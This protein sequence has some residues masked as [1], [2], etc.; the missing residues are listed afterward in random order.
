MNIDQKAFKWLDSNQLSYDIWNKKYRFKGESFDD[1][2][3]RVSSNNENIKR[4]ILEKK[5]SFGG[6]ILANRGLNHASLANCATLGRVKDSINGIMETNTQLAQTFKYQ[7]GQGLSLTDIRP[8]GTPIRGLYPSEG[9]VPFME[10]FNT[11]TESIQQGGSRRGALLMALDIMHK[12]AYD[13]MTIK[14]DLKR[15]NNANLSMEISDEFMGYVEECMANNTNK[16]IHMK[17]QYGND[18]IEYDVDVMKLYNTLCE[19]A[20]KYAEPGILYTD[21]LFNYNLMQHDDDYEILSTNACS[22]QPLVKHGM[23]MLASIN[24][25]KYVQNPFSSDVKFD[26]NSL[27]YDIYDIVKAMDDIVD[28][29]IKL[30]PLQEQKDT[31]QK[32][33]NIGVGIMG[34]A[35]FFVMNNVKY[36][37]N[38]SKQMARDIMKT[39]FQYAIDA[40]VRLGEERGNFPGYKSCVWDSDIIKA[41]ISPRDIEKYKSKGCLRNC[42]LLS[43]APTGSIGTMFQ[44]STGCEPFFALSYKR[45]TISMGEQYYDVNIPTLELYK[46]IKGE[47]ADISNFVTS[48]DIHWVDRIGVQSELQKACDTAISSTCNLPKDTTLEE[49]K[50]IYLEA[51]KSKCKGFT[52]YV[53]GSR[54]P[55]L[56]TSGF[57]SNNGEVPK[58]PKELEAD[59]YAVKVKNEIFEVVVGL[60]NGKPYEVFA[61]RSQDKPLPAHKGKIIKVKKMHYKFESEY[62]TIP[63]LQLNGNSEEK[64]ATLY[65]SMLMRHNADLKY[66]IKTAKKVNDNISSFTSAMCRVLSKYIGAEVLEEKCP[67]CGGQIIREV[68]CCKCNDCGWSKCE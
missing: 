15:I 36:G 4:L 38:E 48:K 33:R 45:R 63:D 28:E 61:M 37:S 16:L 46:S 62:K 14:S 31:A 40:S 23:C 5:F 41:N 19:H 18:F 2:L 13:F 35:D 64:A 12:D 67:E 42:S 1:W 54:N 17:K 21:Q 29:N 3:N 58:R 55:I 20:L 32:Y 39:V 47:D 24:I 8:K 59:Y 6:R 49:I 57:E 52:V 53:E 30:A 22:E 34:L 43:I 9:I 60:L 7:Q 27:K 11:T 56:S 25:S 68:G 50:C 44:I 66:I 10:I 51:W 65:A 26:Y